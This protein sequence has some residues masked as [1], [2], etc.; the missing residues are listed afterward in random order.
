MEELTEE[1]IE[2]LKA[3]LLILEKELNEILTQAND[4][5]KTVDLD[6]PIGRLTRMDAIQQQKMEEA[7][8]NQSKL[9]LGQ[10]NTALRMYQEDEYGYCRKCEEPIGYA[11]LKAKPEAPFCLDCQNSLEKRMK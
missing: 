5:E 4:A 11:R 7:G 9:R 8:R 1:Q 3:D 10:V 6:L 2:E